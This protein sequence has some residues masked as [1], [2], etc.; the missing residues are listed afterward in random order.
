MSRLPDAELAIMKIIWAHGGGEI[1]S[2]QVARELE[3]KKDWAL[4]TVLNF[5]ARL[6]ERGFLSVRRAGKTNIYLPIINEN[7]YLQL[8]SKSFLERLH[9]NS[10]SSLVAALYS[11]AAISQDDLAELKNFIDER[12]GDGA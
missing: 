3:G 1:T 12:A 6:T 10:F 9:G 11:G 5:L 4:T 7:D 8:E 2:A